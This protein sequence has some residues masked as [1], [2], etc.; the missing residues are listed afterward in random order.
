VSGELDFSSAPALRDV[1]HDAV[2][3]VN[4]VLA[5]DLSGVTF[6]DAAGLGV[7]VGERQRLEAR[8]G[9][10]ALSGARPIVARL[11]ELTGLARTPA[12]VGEHV[13]A[14]RARCAPG[15]KGPALE[16]EAPK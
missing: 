2:D 16:E 5:V 13:W 10:M 6:I 7:L 11:L 4:G 8:G 12:G 1:L 3:D 9:A 14:D 15:A